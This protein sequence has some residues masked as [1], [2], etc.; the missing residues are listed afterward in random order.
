THALTPAGPIPTACDPDGV[1]PYVSYFET[2]PR[3][4]W[5]TYRFIALEN[6]RLR[7]VICPDLGGKVTSLIHAGSGPQGLHTPQF[8]KPVRILPRYA[9]VAGGIA[10]S[11]PISHSPSQNDPVFSRIDHA[12][13]RVYVTC[14]ERELRFGMQWSVEY[15]LGPGDLFLTQRAVFHNP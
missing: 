12:A 14:G 1:Y 5:R 7:A 2:S 8:I 11:F 9:F 10:V 15:S 4:V 6:D 3:P 13:S